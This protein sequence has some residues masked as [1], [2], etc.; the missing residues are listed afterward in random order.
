MR[1]VHLFLILIFG[2]CIIPAVDFF[3]ETA[4]EYL[5]PNRQDAMQV[6][7]DKSD[8][9]GRIEASEYALS[10]NDIRN[11][12]RAQARVSK[13]NYNGA[14]ID[15][16]SD[17]NEDNKKRIALESDQRR[18]GQIAR[19]YMSHRRSILQADNYLFCTYH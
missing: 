3:G 1:C 12:K 2:Y 16:A 9:L 17:F 7:I 5:Y 11:V 19:K 6:A 10:E 8:G 14:K 4:I 13:R 18:L 15:N